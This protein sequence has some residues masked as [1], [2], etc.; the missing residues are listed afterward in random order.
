MA[1]TGWDVPVM[2][3]RWEDLTENVVDRDVA[4][5]GSERFSMGHIAL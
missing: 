3:K 5:F 1:H 2:A 4:L